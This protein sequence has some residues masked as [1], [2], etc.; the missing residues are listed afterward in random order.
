[1]I[2]L[3][4]A[5]IMEAYILYNI[6]KPEKMIFMG[7]YLSLFSLALKTILHAPSFIYYF[8]DLNNIILV[9]NI[10]LSKRN[11]ATIKKK[12][13]PL[14]CC[15]TLF[16]IIGV[17][18][19]I[20]NKTKIYL[21]IWS[22]R[23]YLRFFIFFCATICFMKKKYITK[24]Y[25]SLFPII[26]LNTLMSIYQYRLNI[27]Q[28]LIGGVF[29]CE[30]GVNSYSMTFF[31]IACAYY[32][33]AYINKKETLIKVGISMICIFICVILAD[34]KGFY[35]IFIIEFLTIMIFN[36]IK[37]RNIVISAVILIGAVIVFY[38]CNS[39]YDSTNIFDLEYINYYLTK[40]SYSYTKNSINRTDG[41]EIINRLF[42]FETMEKFFGLGLGSGEFCAYFES[43]IFR[44]YSSTHY[45]W[46]L[47]SWLYLETGYIGIIL[48]CLIHLIM[49]KQLL[50]NL[51]IQRNTSIVLRVGLAILTSFIVL[52]IYNSSLRTDCSYML[53]M[54]LGIAYRCIEEKGDKDNEFDI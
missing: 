46:F 43:D 1:M 37:L 26:I 54:M 3:T 5:L 47:Y 44:L 33:D 34:L 28:D 48:Y 35:F 14:I 38:A 17:L 31:I 23:G 39:F 45:F 9:I 18:T 24:I 36:K 51:K 52:I 4:I 8:M 15:I 16:L 6:K 10:Y 21:I 29:G 53:Y 11:K 50:T 25:K 40:S 30:F 20:V 12:Y 13:I 32:I 22:L 49:F 42:N 2:G 7:F 41:I 19:S 27:F